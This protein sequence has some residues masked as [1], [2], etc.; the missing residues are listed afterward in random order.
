LGGGDG[1][2]VEQAVDKIVE[3]E[4]DGFATAWLANIFSLD[5]LTVLALAG[6]KTS[7]IEL[8]T[9][10]VPTYPRHPHALAQQAA[11]V[12]AAVGGRLALGIGRSHQLVI[13]NMF[14]MSYDKPIA[15]MRDYVRV[16]RELTAAG[17]CAV[18]GDAY[19]V[20]APL[21]IAGGS[22]FPIL[23]G[24]LM[25][26]MLELC[27][28]LCDGTL[29]WMTGPKHLA[30]SIVPGLRRSAD[31][32]GRAMPRVV[33]SLPM[34]VTADPAGAREKAAKLFEVYGQLPVYR[35]CLDAE[36]AA[37]PADL[38]LVGSEAD[39]RAGIERVR[40]AGA[41]DFY[42][43]VFPDAEGDASAVRTYEMLKS[44]G[45]KI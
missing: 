24:A 36:G 8:G 23:I 1:A 43:V 44:L 37:G 28:E 29:T 33:C 10:V 21:T 13:E 30:A 3:A 40:D 14:G 25:P 4:R 12:N 38:A 19:R 22:P 32:A 35:A 7:R 5:A 2:T 17:G 11:T 15:H 41:T 45:G 16:L 42:P 27:G 31:A 39:L 6:Q 20:H 9:A 26:K 18:D 34:C